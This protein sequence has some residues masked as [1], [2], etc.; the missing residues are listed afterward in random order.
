MHGFLLY[1]SAVR[2]EGLPVGFSRN[3]A[4]RGATAPVQAL[5]QL[6]FALGLRIVGEVKAFGVGGVT[7]VG[8]ILGKCRRRA[9]ER[10]A[11][12][13]RRADGQNH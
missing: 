6:G 2:R 10:K 3:M 9:A 11:A 5:F 7:N 13:N 4:L 8:A 1:P 12:D